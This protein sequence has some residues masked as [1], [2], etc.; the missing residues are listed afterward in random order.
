M[1]T[2]VRTRRREVGGGDEHT[3]TCR[4]RTTR[5]P[6]SCCLLFP[7]AP[8]L[9]PLLLPFYFAGAPTIKDGQPCARPACSNKHRD[10]KEGGDHATVND[11]AGKGRRFPKCL[12]TGCPVLN[13]R[14]KPT[15]WQT[16]DGKLSELL[17]GQRPLRRADPP[18]SASLR[19][20]GGFR[21]KGNAEG[22]F[23]LLFV[24]PRRTVLPPRENKWE[25]QRVRGCGDT[26]GR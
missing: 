13:L 15:A 14:G 16:T 12:T 24:S 9:F 23:L 8:P 17:S 11:R 4:C 2:H 1:G 10:V 21:R 6:G 18:A 3:H 20:R 19:P 5:R 26:R 22:C 7:R 25:E